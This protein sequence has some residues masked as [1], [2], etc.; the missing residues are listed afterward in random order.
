MQDK[1]RNQ[2]VIKAKYTGQIAAKTMQITNNYEYIRCN[3]MHTN[4]NSNDRKTY[5]L[6]SVTCNNKYEF[7]DFESDAN[8]DC[9]SD[10]KQ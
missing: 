2:N 10:K 6:V 9:Q 1:T 5:E 8:D 3:E 4:S 7:D